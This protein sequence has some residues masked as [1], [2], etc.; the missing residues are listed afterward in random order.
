MTEDNYYLRF[1]G[2][3]RL[4]GEDALE[5]LRHSH[6]CVVG[7]GGVGSWSA[8]ALARSGVGKI[9]L[10]DMD[11]ICIT[12]S[13]RQ[14]H[15][16]VKTLGKSKAGMMAKRIK[17]I[18]PECDVQAHEDFFTK[19]TA[20][21]ILGLGFDGVVDAIDSLNSKCE[22]LH[23]CLRRK[24]PIIAVGGAGGKTDPTKIQTCDLLKTY[25]DPLLS[26]VRKRLRQKYGYSRNIKR[27]FRIEVVFSPEE[28]VYPAGDGSVCSTK[29]HLENNESMRLDCR[30]GYG[31]ITH[32]TATFGMVAAARIIEKVIDRGRKQNEE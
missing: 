21:E 11:E 15:T 7:I 28:L 3:A 1:S 26:Q 6:I 13:N 29:P 23:L 8:E 32:I 31:A 5:I 10:I 14:I 19:N 16:G 27:R 18:N 30:S 12:N 22:L 25:K 2:I 17:D 9:T 20:D 4:Y 24:I